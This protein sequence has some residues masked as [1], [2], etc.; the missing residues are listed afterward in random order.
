[1]L[2]QHH[3]LVT[4]ILRASVVKALRAS[5]REFGSLHITD[6]AERLAD[7]GLGAGDGSNSRSVVIVPLWILWLSVRCEAWVSKG[8]ALTSISLSLYLSISLSI[9]LS[10]YLSI[11]CCLSLPP[12][13][14]P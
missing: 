4:S 5:E 8:L 11:Y 10:I 14:D 2:T 13:L 7:D 1:M 3:E 6:Q 9:S 12:S